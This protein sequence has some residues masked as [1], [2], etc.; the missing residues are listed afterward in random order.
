MLTPFFQEEILFEENIT[1]WIYGFELPNENLLIGYID[2][3]SRLLKFKF[4]TASTSEWEN[5]TDLNLKMR[6]S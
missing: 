1:E 2:L 6:N 3:S 5:L 4:K